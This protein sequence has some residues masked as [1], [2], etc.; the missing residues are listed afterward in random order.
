MNF[1]RRSVL[2]SFLSPE[3]L[4]FRHSAECVFHGVFHVF[5]FAVHVIVRKSYT[6][7]GSNVQAL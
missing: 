6:E 5:W 2:I 1:Q 7:Y 3:R 4:P